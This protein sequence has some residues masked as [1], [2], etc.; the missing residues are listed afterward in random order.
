LSPPAAPVRRSG[1]SA[2]AIRG[3]SRSTIRPAA[4]PARWSSATSGRTGRNYGWRN[5][6]GE[7]DN[8]TNPP[9]AFLPLTEPIWEYNRSFGG[10]ITG[11]FVYR[12]RAL[13]AANQ[14]L[15]FFADFVSGRVWSLALAIDP[16]SGE[17][18]ASN[19][20]DHTAALGDI[21]NVSSFG[22]DADGELYIVSYSH[23]TIIR[24]IGPKTAPPTPSGPHIIR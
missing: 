4:A 22:L 18:T 5:R 23:G 6:E 1:A 11:G 20:V 17:A 21:G 12:G 3:A 10:S 15:Y 19:M 9:P 24:M 7:H 14:G 2:F 8:I 16:A 13:G